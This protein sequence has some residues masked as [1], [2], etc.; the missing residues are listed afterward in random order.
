[1]GPG[2]RRIRGAS[3]V[4]IEQV[5]G[6]P[7]LTVRLDR[8]ALA[9]DGLSISE[10]Q[11]IVE[12]AV[13]GKS[14]GKLFEGDRRFDIV[15]RLPE[16]L[17]G[18]LEAIRAIPIPLP[19]GEEATSGAPIRT[20][21]PG[22]PLAQMRYVPLS[23]VATVDATPGPNQISRENGKRRIVVTDLAISSS[24]AATRCGCSR[25][26]TAWRCRARFP[27]HRALRPPCANRGLR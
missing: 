22:S 8:Q 2:I 27:R 16:H 9:R 13:G 6:L 1:V 15:V 17:R 14:A 7:I 21:L 25:Q 4:K 24:R 10:V 19:P 11:G 5:S 18:N 23:S 12:I 20:A 26:S 3:D